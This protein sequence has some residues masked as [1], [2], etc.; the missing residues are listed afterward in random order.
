[1]IFRHVQRK[2]LQWTGGTRYRFASG[3]TSVQAVRNSG[4][5][6]PCGAALQTTGPSAMSRRYRRQSRCKNTRQ[7][8]HFLASPLRITVMRTTVGAQVHLSAR[9]EYGNL[10]SS[11]KNRATPSTLRF[12]EEKGLIH[13]IGRQGQRRLFDARYWSDCPSSPLG[14]LPGSHWKKSAQCCPLTEKCR[15]VAKC[16]LPRQIRCSSPSSG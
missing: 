12:Y 9:A 15:S 11:K 13:S 14:A 10:R 16:C 6:R 5:Q 4:W 3:G 1:M 2:L 8:N 7:I